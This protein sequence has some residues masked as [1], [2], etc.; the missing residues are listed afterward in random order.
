MVLY[1]QALLYDLSLYHL[2]HSRAVNVDSEIILM[3]YK[4][5]P[6]SRH[7][8]LLGF[9]CESDCEAVPTPVH[10]NKNRCNSTVFRNKTGSE[11][12]PTEGVS[13]HSPTPADRTP[14]NPPPKTN[15]RG[16]NRQLRAGQQQ[17]KRHR[18]I[19]SK[20]NQILVP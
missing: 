20:S 8:S 16:K 9:F 13:N 6:F 11:R 18:M 12:T 14:G 4:K 1:K 19:G 3:L 10:F 5:K 7:H 17:N 15:D 2:H